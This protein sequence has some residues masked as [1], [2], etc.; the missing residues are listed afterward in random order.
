M[1]DKFEPVHLPAPSDEPV[2]IP[3]IPLFY[4]GDTEYRIPEKPEANV[5]LRY[6]RDARTRGEDIAAAN[7]LIALVGEDAFDALCDY[8]GLAE[9]QLEAVMKAAQKHVMGGLEKSRGN[10]ARGRQR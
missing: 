3:T 10:S 2:E 9:E 1:S 4:L 7:L 6:L 8:P 5:A